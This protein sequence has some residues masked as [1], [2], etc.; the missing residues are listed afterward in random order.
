M[1]RGYLTGLSIFHRDAI[2]LKILNFLRTYYTF[3]INFTTF[4]EIYQIIN[5]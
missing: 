5:S 1:W 2:L 4:A 3:I